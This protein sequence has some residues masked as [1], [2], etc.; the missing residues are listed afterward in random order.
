MFITDLFKTMS[1]VKKLNKFIDKHENTTKKVIAEVQ[2][3]LDFLQ[4]HK[5]DI[6]AK[7]EMVKT[8][9]SKIKGKSKK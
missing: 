5:E 1:A 8:I 9:L 6:E 2:E 3:A 4:E 7:I